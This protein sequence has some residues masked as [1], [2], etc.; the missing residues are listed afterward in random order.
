MVTC[1][2]VRRP[3]ASVKLAVVGKMPPKLRMR[4]A[5][6]DLKSEQTIGKCVQPACSSGNPFSGALTGSNMQINIRLGSNRVAADTFNRTM[7]AAKSDDCLHT[8]ILRENTAGT[9]SASVN[10]RKIHTDRPLT[11]GYN[12]SR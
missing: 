3:Y 11:A 6:K 4:P 2:Y 7:I 10:N 8:S 12:L 5:M 1:Q 9:T